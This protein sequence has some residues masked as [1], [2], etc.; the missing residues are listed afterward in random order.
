MGA[1]AGRFGKQHA[2]VAEDS[3]RPL[4]D[5]RETADQRGPVQR[6]EF[7]KAAAIN[8]PRDDLAYIP[9]FAGIDRNETVELL[10]I[11]LGFIRRGVVD[12]SALVTEVADRLA[13]ERQGMGVVVCHVV[14]EA[15][16][17]A[18][19][20]GTAQF[21]RG[22]DLPGSCLDQRRSAEENGPLPGHDDRLV[23][24]GRDIG[25]ARSAR[26][27]HDRDLRDPPRRH[28][29]L[30]VEASPEVITVWKHFVLQ[31]QV[32]T[33]GIHEVNARQRI[34]G[35]DVLGAQVLLDRNGVVRSAFH[36]CIVHDQHAGPSGDRTDARDE[37]GG[38]RLSV[39]QIAG[40][41]RREFQKRRPG[42]QQAID[43]LPRQQLTAGNVPLARSG[44]AALTN[45]LDPGAEFVHQCPHARPVG[46]VGNPLD[47]EPAC[48]CGH[49]G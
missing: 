3:D 27:H 5:L 35:G 6:L 49:D 47:V 26:S 19:H 38:R 8:D 18:V 36:R 46:P 16:P 45:R 42:V 23:G 24:H 1:L 48:Q 44:A 11:V 29:G 41:Q 17:A 22:H 15:G 33:A 28:S 7:V 13:H 21:L 20:V 34:L 25:A 12:R 37:S 30:V 39:V 32:G 14:D 43:P 2:V 9:G 31:G 4:P 40:R 10:R